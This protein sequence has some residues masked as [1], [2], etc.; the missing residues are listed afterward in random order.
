MA[1]LLF[2]YLQ[3]NLGRDELYSSSSLSYNSTIEEALKLT[4]YIKDHQRPLVI[5]KENSFM[6]NELYEMMAPFFEAEELVIY[7]PEESM[8][9]EAIVASFENRAA[10]ISALSAI[11]K[12]T[13][14]AIITTAYGLIRHLPDKDYLKEHMVDLKVGDIIERDTLIA[15]LK[16]CGYER[17]PTCE[18]PL[19]YALRGSIIDVFSAD[20]KEPLRIEF[21]DDEIDS[22]RFFDVNTQMTLRKVD[23]CSLTFASDVLFTDL[24]IK[25]LEEKLDFSDGQMAIDI[26]FIKEHMYQGDLYYYYAFLDHDM[27]LLGYLDDPMLYLSDSYRTKEHIRILADETYAYLREMS[28]DTLRPLRFYVFGDY[29]K[30]I[31]RVDLLKSEPLSEIVPLIT[32][33]DVPRGPLE[34]V[35]KA[36]ARDREKTIVFILDETS[37]ADVVSA[38]SSLDVDYVVADDELISGI[39]IIYGDLYE[40]FEVKKLDLIVYGPKELL[41]HKKSLGRY[42]RRYEESVKLDSYEELQRGDYVVH[43]QYGIGQ[44]VGI[45]KRT[46]NNVQLDYLKILYRGNDELL[47]PLSQFSLVRKYVSKDGVVPKLHKLGSKE[48]TKTKEKVAEGIDDLAERLLELYQ[49]RSQN[50]GFA[51]SK[52]NDIQ[53]TF[54]KEFPYELTPDQTRSIIEVKKDMED[55]KP[56]DRL[57][58]GDVGFG[59]TEVAIRA[60]MKAVLD[61]KQV[62]YLCPTTILSL[63]HLKTF[64]ERFK[65]YPVR[66]ELL[67]RYILPKDQNKIIADIKDGKVDIVIGTHRLLSKDITYKDLGLLIV[68]EEQRFGVEHKEK[69]KQLK[70]S[71]DVLSLSATPIPRTLQMSLVGLRGLSTLDTPPRDRYPIQTYVVEKNDDLIREVIQRELSRSGQV[72]YLYNDIEMIFSIAKKIERNVKGAKVLVAH[73]KMSREE[74]ED[75]MRDFYEDKANVLICTTIIETGID[76]P[77]T[78]T[79]IIDG[80]QNFGLAQLY[81]IRGR[82]GRSDKI[83]YAYL[84][85]PPKKQLSEVAMKRLDAIKEFTALGSGYKIAMRDLAIR[86]AGDMLGAKQSGFIDNVGLDLYLSMLEKAIRKKKGEDIKDEEVIVRPNLPIDSFI[87]DTFEDNDYDKLSMYHH[88]DEISSRD[89]LLDYYLEIKDRY[90]RLPKEIESVF[91]KKKIELFID[92]KIVDSFKIIDARMIITLTKEYSD[93]IDGMKLFEYCAELSK[94]LRIRYTKAKIEFSFQNRKEEMKKVTKLLDHLD[95]VLKDEDR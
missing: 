26:D 91:E 36:I 28:E 55:K 8:R 32:E 3:K 37:I 16:E 78:N 18:T 59:K 12:A 2:D 47:V 50:I 5:V 87:P 41:Y 13:P 76:I 14:K 7:D 83:A 6:A 21:F 90:G 30:E 66:I 9:A 33:V 79:I 53:R 81:Q 15:R 86:G 54:E 52:D 25:E 56:M 68:D 94:D 17:V 49:R 48:W 92:G 82:V 62:A 20:S 89:D 42:A 65:N 88:L 22:L 31:N 10:R 29:N 51:F 85:I 60:S 44:Y 93:R 75:A 80:A 72:F 39:N 46:V 40:G 74:I 77:N 27:H 43:D 63:Q 19:T 58:C 34:L 11:L 69:I 1:D 57:L 67:N 95:E 45:E 71:I 24:E 70:E 23:K 38:L 35:L 61:H 4:F 64:K 84:M 73:G